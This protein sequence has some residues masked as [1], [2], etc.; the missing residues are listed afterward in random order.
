MSIKTRLKALEKVIRPGVIR[1]FLVLIGLD[2]SRCETSTEIEV[3]S[4]MFEAV[5]IGGVNVE[6][7]I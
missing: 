7:D 5:E 1:K 6:V 2:G 4:G 3:G